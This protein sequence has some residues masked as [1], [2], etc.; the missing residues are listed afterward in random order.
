MLQGSR[1]DRVDSHPLVIN[2]ELSRDPEM[3]GQAKRQPRIISPSVIKALASVDR[4]CTQPQ[5]STASDPCVSQLGELMN[6][7]SAIIH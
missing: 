3:R 6:V 7:Q 4:L 5:I 1:P 2:T